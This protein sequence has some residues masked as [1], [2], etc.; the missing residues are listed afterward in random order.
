M[1]QALE[2]SGKPGLRVWER[3]SLTPLTVFS[4]S[5]LERTAMWLHASVPWHT[6]FP[7]PVHLAG[8]GSPL[9]TPCASPGGLDL[10]RCSQL[11]PPLHLSF[12]GL[13]SLTCP[14]IDDMFVPCWIREPRCEKK[15]VLVN[16]YYVFSIFKFQ[17]PA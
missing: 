15:E 8:S 7:L 13:L 2:E 10:P 11:S 16:K 17:S 3:Y 4:K 5:D 9:E 12:S 1:S 6:A 14:F